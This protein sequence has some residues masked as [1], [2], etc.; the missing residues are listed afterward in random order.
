MVSGGHI[1]ADYRD[2]ASQEL[3]CLRSGPSPDEQ[4]LGIIV[5]FIARCGDDAQD[6]IDRSQSVLGTV[7][8]ASLGIWPT[9]DQW[10]RMLP[11]WFLEC[12]AKEYTTEEAESRLK[13][14]RALSPEDQVQV[15]REARWTLNNW[16]YH[17]QPDNRHWFWWD[18][19]IMSQDTASVTVVV[20]GC[21]FPWGALS[22][23]LRASGAKE[24]LPLN[25]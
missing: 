3:R 18:A 19:R 5:E 2:R 6:V 22:W 21:P 14:W 24:V 4:A 9:N 1:M 17:F 16:L 10:R 25:D 15:D 23:L 8:Q 13:W 7:V 11:R 20:D 12:C